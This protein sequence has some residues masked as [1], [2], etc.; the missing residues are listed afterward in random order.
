[1]K[2]TDGI[3][4]AIPSDDVKKFLAKADQYKQESTCFPKVDLFDLF[5]CW[6][7]FCTGLYKIEVHKILVQKFY[8]LAYFLL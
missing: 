5:V 6:C 2:I 1:M 7:E 4:F 3:S 8:T